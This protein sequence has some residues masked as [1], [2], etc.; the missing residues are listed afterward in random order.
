MS[1]K[2]RVTINVAQSLNGLIAYAAIF[3]M[4][5]AGRKCLYIVPLKALAFE[6][7][8]EMKARALPG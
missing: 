2:V 8:E 6:K 5:K 3:N 4:I 1:G 7:Y